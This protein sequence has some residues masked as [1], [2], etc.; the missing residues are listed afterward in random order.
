MKILLSK[1]QIK[2]LFL[3]LCYVLFGPFLYLLYCLIVI[4]YSLVDF[5]ISIIPN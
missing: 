3:Y 4:S 5:K 1:I 2:V